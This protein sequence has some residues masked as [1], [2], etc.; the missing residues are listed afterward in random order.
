MFQINSSAATPIYRQI[1]DQVRREVVGGQLKPGDELPS[2]RSVALL[3]AINPMTVSKAYG[4][5][6]AEGLL[7]RQRGMAMAVAEQA[8]AATHQ[9]RQTL[10]R[11]HLEA[12]ARAA[13]QLKVSPEAALELFSTYL[14][15]NDKKETP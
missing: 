12:A 8:S 6:E 2:V 3:H 7:V 10:L 5:L 1:V 4:L 15:A 11:P 9:Q 14:K 13:H